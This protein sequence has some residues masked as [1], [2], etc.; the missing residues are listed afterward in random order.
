MK[1]TRKISN[2]IFP[3][4]RLKGLIATDFKDV[5]N[6]FIWIKDGYKKVFASIFPNTKK[7][8]ILVDQLSD[9]KFLLTTW[10]IEKH[11]IKDVIRA[12][13]IRVG[14]F[15]FVGIL[16]LYLCFKETSSV[17]QIVSG[18]LLVIVSFY[19]CSVS[20]WRARVLQKE[21]F[22]KFSDWIL[23]YKIKNN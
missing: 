7:S 10:G 5:K 19:A 11:E 21:Q 1:K 22:I 3:G 18:T 2:F 4:Q 6:N 23:G 17:L 16:G 12:M 14:G 15:L 8:Q 9:F 20:I 13:Y